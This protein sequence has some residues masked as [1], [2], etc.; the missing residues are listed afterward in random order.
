[1]RG[2]D[3]TYCFNG[4]SRC[5]RSHLWNS[6]A[7][8]ETFKG[9]AC[10]S[11]KS[12][13]RCTFLRE[14]AP[15]RCHGGLQHSSCPRYLEQQL[16]SVFPANNHRAQPTHRP[17]LAF[18]V[19]HAGWHKEAVCESLGWGWHFQWASCRFGVKLY[20]LAPA[21]GL[22]YLSLEV[23]V[24]VMFGSASSKELPNLAS[25]ASIKSGLFVLR[26]CIFCDIFS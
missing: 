23:C 7:G 14:D 1:M 6:E 22:D 10:T 25:F 24:P 12:S 2:L 21:L 26:I 15:S 9:V 4:F 20:M 17:A 3:I 19:L 5:F 16:L 8:E 13:N 11:P 18:G